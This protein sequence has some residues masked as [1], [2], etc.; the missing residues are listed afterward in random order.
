MGKQRLLLVVVFAAIVA[1]ALAACT[2][3]RSDDDSREPEDESAAAE[4]TTSERERESDAEEL[5]LDTWEAHSPEL[6]VETL[7]ASGP[8][9]TYEAVR[10]ENTYVGEVTEELFISVSLDGGYMG[11]SPDEVAVYLCDGD[12]TQI[13]LS[14]ELEPQMTSL[15]EDGAQVELAVDEDTDVVTGTVTLDDGPGQAFEAVPAEE[16]AGLY[17]AQLTAQEIDFWGGWVV[18]NDGRQQG[19]SCCCTLVDGVPPGCYSACCVL[20]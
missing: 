1:L 3:S 4:D 5:D 16:N 9:G 18:L 13:M 11:S 20:N 15:S 8:E 2:T 10:H 7:E 19:L 17:T 14:G 6:N 12:E